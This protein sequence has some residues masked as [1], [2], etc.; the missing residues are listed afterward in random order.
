MRTPGMGEVKKTY[1]LATKLEKD[2]EK[3]FNTTQNGYL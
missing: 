1:Y 2:K 3:Y